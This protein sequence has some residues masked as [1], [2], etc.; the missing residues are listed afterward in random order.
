V[1]RFNGRD[2]RPIGEL[3]AQADKAMYEEKRRRSKFLFGPTATNQP[4]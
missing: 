2:S 3:M 1:A 4:Q